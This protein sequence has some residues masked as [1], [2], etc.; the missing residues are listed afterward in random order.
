MRR[1]CR[2]CR[3]EVKGGVWSRFLSKHVK[4]GDRNWYHGVVP[5]SD[6]SNAEA[7]GPVVELEEEAFSRLVAQ[8]AIQ[9]EVK[10][11]VDLWTSDR[12]VDP[13]APSSEV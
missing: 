13:E 11:D 7:C 5:K 1:A 2:K 10:R 3:R 4:D 6:T 12:D 8:G 9:V